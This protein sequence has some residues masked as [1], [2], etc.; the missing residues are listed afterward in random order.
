M[1]LAEEDETDEVFTD[2]SVLL[3]YVLDQGDEGAI[4]LITSSDRTII[5]SETVSSEFER[6]PERRDDIYID[7]LKIVASEEESIENEVVSQRDYLEGSD[8]SYFRSLRDKLVEEGPEYRL[9]QL[10]EHQKM[11]DRRYGQTMGIMSRVLDENKD[12]LLISKIARCIGNKDDGKVICD[13]AMWSGEGGNGDLATL[14]IRHI[15]SNYSEIN[16]IIKSHHGPGH[17]LQ[18]K[19]PIK[20]VS[21]K[22]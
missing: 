3:N 19:K 1:S 7:I 20:Y 16:E 8:A 9:K 21:D 22:R 18:I 12:E 11:I 14:D 6:V 10:R 17:T 2:T 15:L 4:K 13:A 5:I